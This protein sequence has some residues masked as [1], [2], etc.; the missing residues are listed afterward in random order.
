M[1]MKPDISR[2]STAIATAAGAPCPW[3][4]AQ[5]HRRQQSPSPSNGSTRAPRRAS[6][7]SG[8][9]TS[10]TTAPT[11]RGASTVGLLRT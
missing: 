7:S 6:A 1:M 3:L 8:G 11:L 2:P 10:M 9:D 5:S 4:V